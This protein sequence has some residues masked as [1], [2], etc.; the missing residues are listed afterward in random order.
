MKQ[1]LLIGFLGLVFI[2]LLVVLMPSGE[3]T[4]TFSG[5]V[6]N[7]YGVFLSGS[8]YLVGDVMEQIYQADLTW[9]RTALDTRALRSTNDSV[10]DTFTFPTRPADWVAFNSGNFFIRV[11]YWTTGVNCTINLPVTYFD[12]TT[13]T[14][15]INIVGNGI[16]NIVGS[17]KPVRYCSSSQITGFRGPV[18]TR[19][20]SY[21]VN[22]T[23]FGTIYKNTNH[24]SEVGS[25]SSYTLNQ[26]YIKADNIDVLFRN[27]SI[28]FSL[29]LASSV[30]FYQTGAS[31]DIRFVNCS[32]N[33][34]VR[35]SMYNNYPFDAQGNSITMENCWLRCPPTANAVDYGAVSLGADTFFNCTNTTILGFGI[36]G[37]VLNMDNVF[38][39]DYPGGVFYA[40][41]FSSMSNITVAKCKF[42]LWVYFTSG[43]TIRDSTFYGNDYLFGI[44]MFE[45]YADIIDCVSDVFGFYDYGET[46]FNGG[47][48]NWSYTAK[49]H[50][51]YASNNSD[52]SDVD[53]SILNGTGDVIASG[54][55]DAYGHIPDKL[56]QVMF[57]VTE[58]PVD[59]NPFTF[60]L[61]KSGYEWLNVSFTVV[62]KMNQTFFIDEVTANVTTNI[63]YSGSTGSGRSLAFLLLGCSTSFI[64]GAASIVIVLRKKEN[65]H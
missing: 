12:F 36:W 9:N 52:A 38:I 8:D 18:A 29:Q 62:D 60:S 46:P 26:T 45:A 22:Q 16:Y 30:Q 15:S 11:Y 57:W 4:I 27:T 56:L 1:I 2:G 54:T 3:S 20:I 17:G 44:D 55:T 42:P 39:S 14:I 7:K 59:C 37:G 43:Y 64:I 48:I 34:F 40:N 61:H 53:V 33:S 28:F 50:V 51:Q 32:V 5:T 13:G 58:T 63:F 41:V 49:T 21:S 31:S 25:T 65:R 10:V 6:L 24:G 47:R 23:R 19:K 35:Y